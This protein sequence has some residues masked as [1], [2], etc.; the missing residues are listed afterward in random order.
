MLTWAAIG[1]IGTMENYSEAGNAYLGSHR[2]HRNRT[3]ISVRIQWCAL[4][5]WV[6]Y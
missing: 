3:S 4:Q 5:P 6:T 1:T 2:N